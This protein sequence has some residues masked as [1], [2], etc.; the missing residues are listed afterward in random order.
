M[1]EILKKLLES[2]LLSE[3]SKQELAEAFQAQLT[4][5]IDEAKAAAAAET[6]VELHEQFAQQ[7]EQLVE[8]VDRTIN[9][10]IIAEFAALKDDIKAFRD[11]EA[12]K[13]IELAKEKSALAKTLKEDMAVLV[14]QLDKFL[15][16]RFATEFKDIRDD[17]MKAKEADFGREVFESFLPVY[18]KYFVNPTQTEAEL[19]EAKVKL[20]KL[21]KKYKNIKK[22]KDALYR[23]IRVESVLAPLSGSKRDLMESILSSVATENLESAYKRYLPRVLKETADVTDTKQVVTEGFGDD[24]HLTS[25]TIDLNESVIV[26]GDT[27]GRVDESVDVSD[28]L[29]SQFARLAGITKPF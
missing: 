12:E 16:E 8:A 22:D 20:D 2:E 5:A 15:E 6:K 25:K 26:S 28:S 23:R 24:S 4:E 1:N 9:E 3:E 7:K 14:K 13:A 19:T 11:L 18:R 21:N 10:F 27:S 29:A 17:L